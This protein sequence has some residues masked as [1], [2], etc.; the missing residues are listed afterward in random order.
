[1]YQTLVMNVRYANLMRREINSQKDRR[2]LAQKEANEGMSIAF[3][4]GVD[5]GFWTSSI[6]A[7]K[8]KPIEP[9]GR[10]KGNLFNDRGPSRK[11]NPY[12]SLFP[13]LPSVQ[14]LLCLLLSAVNS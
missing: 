14:I 5:S 2:G 8:T 6:A 10:T 4:L 12:P 11:S 13:L 9:T 3:Q 7:S 1:M